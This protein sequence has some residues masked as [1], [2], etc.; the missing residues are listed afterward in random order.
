MAEFMDHGTGTFFPE[1][2]QEYVATESRLR[3]GGQVV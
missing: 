3:G 2:F 1:M